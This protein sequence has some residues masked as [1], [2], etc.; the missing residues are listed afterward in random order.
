MVTKLIPEHH[1]EVVR[2]RGERELFRNISM[3]LYINKMTVLQY[4]NDT[5]IINKT[6]QYYFNKYIPFMHDY[7]SSYQSSKTDICNP[8]TNDSTDKTRKGK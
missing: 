7:L 1:L 4:D 3:S 8:Q 2:Q 6:M 5:N